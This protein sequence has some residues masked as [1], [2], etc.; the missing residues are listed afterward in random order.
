MGKVISLAE[1]RQRKALKGDGRLEKGFNP[2][3]L[4]LRERIARIHASIQR[5]NKM[6]EDVR[7]GKESI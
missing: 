6:M 4:E 5:I 2:N 7:N 3:E 1:A